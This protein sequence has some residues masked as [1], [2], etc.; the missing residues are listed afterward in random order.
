VRA[1][2]YRDANSFHEAFKK[3]LFDVR[4]RTI[5][6]AGRPATIFPRCVTSAS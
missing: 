3:G 4:K 5:P 6:A 1:D 2:Y